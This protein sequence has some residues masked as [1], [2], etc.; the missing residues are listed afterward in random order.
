M[1]LLKEYSN[2]SLASRMK[3]EAAHGGSTVAAMLRQAARE[4]KSGAQGS[5]A[6]ANPITVACASEQGRAIAPRP[7]CSSGANAR[8]YSP[9]HCNA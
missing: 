4:R 1:K 5:R 9:L 3:E 2:A 6:N 7:P 8:A